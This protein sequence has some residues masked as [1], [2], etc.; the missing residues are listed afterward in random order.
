MGTND[1]S[2][3]LDKVVFVGYF[4]LIGST[5][6]FGT[7]EQGCP[8]GHNIEHHQGIPSNLQPLKRLSHIVYV[9]I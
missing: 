1:K 7:A 8:L 2:T 6:H 4:C 3:V 5:Y 9:V